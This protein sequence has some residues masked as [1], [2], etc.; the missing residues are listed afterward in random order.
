MFQVEYAFER[1]EVNRN[2]RVPSL[3]FIKFY[4]QVSHHI[5]FNEWIILVRRKKKWQCLLNYL[6]NEHH[7]HGNLADIDKQT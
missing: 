6:H 3:S 4:V 1:N 7:R 5:V 2:T